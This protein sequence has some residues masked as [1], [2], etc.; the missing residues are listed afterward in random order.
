[1]SRLCLTS[2]SIS[3]STPSSD[4]KDSALIEIKIGF[5]SV[6]LSLL[7]LNNIV[8]KMYLLKFL[9][10]KLHYLAGI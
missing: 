7:Q 1:M 3:I 8:K 2:P 6:L 10:K 4:S 9:G 5:I